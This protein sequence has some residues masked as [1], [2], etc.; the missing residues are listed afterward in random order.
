[1]YPLVLQLQLVACTPFVSDLSIYRRK[2]LPDNWHECLLY[3]SSR[4]IMASLRTILSKLST[5]RDNTMSK[6]FN[7]YTIFVQL[8]TYEFSIMLNSYFEYCARECIVKI[9]VIME[10]ILRYKFCVTNIPSFHNI[11]LINDMHTLGSFS[12]NIASTA[13]TPCPAGSMSPYQS[14]VL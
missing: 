3:M 13:C 5:F 9:Y 11:F 6:T 2:L 4:Y 10:S 1:M 14:R 7:Y 12:P 8:L